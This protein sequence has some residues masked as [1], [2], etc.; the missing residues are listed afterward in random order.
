M[1]FV[2]VRRLNRVN[3]THDVDQPFGEARVELPINQVEVQLDSFSQHGAAV[4]RRA[5][6]LNNFNRHTADGPFQQRLS[7]ARRYPEWR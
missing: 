6:C 4:C 7:A 3:I 5:L 1:V 2:G